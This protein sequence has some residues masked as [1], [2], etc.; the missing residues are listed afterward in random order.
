MACRLLS[1]QLEISRAAQCESATLCLVRLFEASGRAIVVVVVCVDA[2]LV[3]V[4]LA[5]PLFVVVI[6]KLLMLT[7]LLLIIAQ[8]GNLNRQITNI[9]LGN[10]LPLVVVHCPKLGPL[11]TRTCL[12]SAPHS[13]LL[14]L[15]Q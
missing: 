8:G 13:L 9:Q 3:V 15:L 6:V 11:H 2:D 7:K 14:L 10:H 12:L 4:A 5:Q 1:G